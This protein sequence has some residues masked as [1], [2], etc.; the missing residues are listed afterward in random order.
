MPPFACLQTESA[1]VFLA[2]YRPNSPR[3]SILCSHTRSMPS[4]ASII[5]ASASGCNEIGFMIW[6][7]VLAEGHLQ[8]VF[9]SPIPAPTR[10]GTAPPLQPNNASTSASDSSSRLS[11]IHFVGAARGPSIQLLD[12][13]LK[14]FDAHVCLPRSP[15]LRNHP[16]WDDSTALCSFGQSVPSLCGPASPFLRLSARGVHHQLCLVVT[17]P[18]PLTVPARRS[19]RCLHSRSGCD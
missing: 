5:S 9:P 7:P 4:A 11:S 16:Y 6:L 19:K 3:S 18:C 2:I 15:W 14:L 8:Q 10:P 17:P 13:S 1:I 12:F